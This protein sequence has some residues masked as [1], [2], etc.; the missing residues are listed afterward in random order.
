MVTER[1]SDRI[2]CPLPDAICDRLRVHFPSIA[3]ERVRLRGR[4]PRWVPGRPAGFA[5]GW[6]VHLAPHAPSLDTLEGIALIAHELVHVRQFAELGAWRFRIRY[7]V[8]YL[9]GRLR[10]LSHDAAYRAI[11]FECEARD[12]AAAILAE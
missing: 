7:L 11:S 3:L 8:E 6:C 2:D 9:R 12:V 5:H 1:P 4:I 10:G